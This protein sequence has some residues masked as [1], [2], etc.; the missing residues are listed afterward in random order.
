MYVKKQPQV[1]WQMKHQKDKF[2][3]INNIVQK[4]G[5]SNSLLLPQFH[6]ISGCD[7]TSFFFYKRRKIPF[8][9]AHSSGLLSLLDTL[10]STDEILVETIDDC[11]EFIR[12][13]IYNG[14]TGETY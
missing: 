3:D 12:S 13:V 5:T 4:L 6:A 8:K 7:I 1:Q 11:T 14:K 2:A 10:G 9:K